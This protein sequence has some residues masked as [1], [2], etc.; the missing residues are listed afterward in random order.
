METASITP[1]HGGKVILKSLPFTFLNREVTV[2]DF[3][4]PAVGDRGGMAEVSGRSVPVSTPDQRA[5]AT[6]DIELMTTTRVQARDMQLTLVAN[7][8]LFLHVPN[9]CPVPGGHV[10]VGDAG[11]E[12]RTRSAR[13]ERRYW[14]L[15]CRL[16]APPP[17]GVSAST[18]TYA[19]LLAL[20]GGYDNVLA[21]NSEYADLLQL[22]GTV[23]DL[24]VI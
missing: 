17:P 24:V 10:R 13:S 2:T 22:M 21:A 4:D 9:G 1:S 16:V 12:R 23:D 19:G 7:P 8:H 6:F 3:T 15:P 18:M 14:R 5:S 11:E 20:Y